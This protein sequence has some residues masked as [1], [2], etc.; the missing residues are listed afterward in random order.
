MFWL[1]VMNRVGFGV[2]E[3]DGE[4]EV[5]GLA[6]AFGDGDEEADVSFAAVSACVCPP[7]LVALP[8]ADPGAVIDGTDRG[9]ALADPV[10]DGDGLGDGLG[11][12]DGIGDGTAGTLGA[13]DGNPACARGPCGDV[14]HCGPGG[15]A[16][17]PGNCVV[18]NSTCRNSSTA[19]VSSG[20]T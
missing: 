16:G 12:N 3:G 2:P 6:E 9:A 18:H 5:V 15:T 13:D 4:G 10:P 8:L 1:P 14:A 7:D 19:A 17:E 20:D 11:G